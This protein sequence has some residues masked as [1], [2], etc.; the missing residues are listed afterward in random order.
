MQKTMLVLLMLIT[1]QTNAGNGKTTAFHGTNGRD[2]SILNITPIDD[3]K[4]S[5]QGCHSRNNCWQSYTMQ[6]P[7]TH[8]NVYTP[9]GSIHPSITLEFKDAKHVILHRLQP[10]GINTEDWDEIKTNF[11][12]LSQ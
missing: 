6:R 8:T 9:P 2:D 4:L 7:N 5:V 11:Y 10:A 12:S 3:L 1:C